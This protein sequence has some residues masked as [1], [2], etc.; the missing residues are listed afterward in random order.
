MISATK[1]YKKLQ[2][3]VYVPKQLE[4]IENGYATPSFSKIS[5]LNS[6]FQWILIGV[7]L[8]NLYL[9]VARHPPYQFWLIAATGAVK[10][11]RNVVDGGVPSSPAI[12]GSCKLA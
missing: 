2:N 3:L 7:M 11:H 4:F 5:P 8:Q 12:Y 1:N 10:R 9:H 6:H